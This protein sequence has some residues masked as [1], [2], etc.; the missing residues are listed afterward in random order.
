MSTSYRVRAALTAF[1]LV[2]PPALHA[3]AM[4]KVNDSVNV[5][6]GF[7]SQTW[8]DFTQNV[9][10][11][12]SYAQNIFQRRIRFLVGAQ[13]GSHLSFFYET[14]NPNLGRTGQTAGVKNLASGFITQDA[15]AEVKPGTTNALLIDA[16]LQLVPLCRNCLQ[17]AATLLPLD[18]GAYSFLATGPTTSSVGRDVGFAARG[19]LV[20][21]RLEYRAG[22]FSGLR[23]TIGTVQTG[24]NSLRFAGRLQYNFL[25]PEAPGYTYT[26]TYLGRRRVF[27]LGAGLDGQSQYK[28]FAGDLFLDYPLGGGGLTVQGDY[29]H[30]DG[31]TSGIFSIVGTPAY[32]GKQNTY[33]VEAGYYIPDY[34]LTPWV[35]WEARDFASSNQGVLFPANLD[36]SRFQVGATWYVVGHNLNLK[37]AY[38]RINSDRLIVAGV[39]PPAYNANSFTMQLQGFYY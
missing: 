36:E 10:Q 32:I 38:Q 39:T 26:G 35:K 6:I 19:Y 12:S 27:A 2:L 18:Y 15:Y 21:Q 22:L 23:N 24:S 16:G 28:A 33:E 9:R 13:V 30:Y 4:I 34:K 11:D 20:D 7:L 25:E 1:A 17:S 37:L 31:S 14:D 8:A 5:R 29:I 3:Q